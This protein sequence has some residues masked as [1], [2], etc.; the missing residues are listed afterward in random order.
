MRVLTPPGVFSPRSDS[1]LLAEVACERVDRGSALLDVCTGSG[2]VAVSAALAGAGAVTAVD[3]SR[4]AVLAA[5]V[6]A[7]INGARIDARRGSLFEPVAGESFDLIVANPPY[8]PARDGAKPSGAARAWD[9]GADGR[10]LLDP[11]IA[12]APSHLRPGGALLVVQSSITGEQRTLEAMR[13][14]GFSSSVVRRDQSPLGPLHRDRAELLEARGLLEPGV[15]H[16]DVLV[17]R[18]TRRPSG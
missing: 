3:V 4:R 14:A 2:V 6:N 15:R 13:A 11:L 5:R 16:E 10:E 18:G 7:R 1:W 17:I 12:G 9:A 8:V